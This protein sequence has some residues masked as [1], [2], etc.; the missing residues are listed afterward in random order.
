[1]VWAK[2][3]DLCGNEVQVRRGPEK[4]MRDQEKVLGDEEQGMWDREG[5]RKGPG[6]GFA[7]SGRDTGRD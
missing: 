5:I 4:A 1:M 2:G 6:G 3:K 7:V